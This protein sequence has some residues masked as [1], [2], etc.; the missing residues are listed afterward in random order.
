MWL[1]LKQE[2]SAG[3]QEL[4]VAGQVSSRTSFIPILWQQELQVLTMESSKCQ[5]HWEGTVGTH[6]RPLWFTRAS[7]RMSLKSLSDVFRVC[8]CTRSNS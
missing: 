2:T 1:I 5:H 6:R 4:A 8:N 3:W 7:N